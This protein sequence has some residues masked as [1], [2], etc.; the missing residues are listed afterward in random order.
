M[1]VSRSLPRKTTPRFSFRLTVQFFSVALGILGV[2]SVLVG[3]IGVALMFVCLAMFLGMLGRISTQ[4]EVLQ[5]SS[6]RLEARIE[7][8][9]HKMTE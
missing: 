5:T 8:L 3:N 1:N 6:E 7:A 9:R 2:L 4:L